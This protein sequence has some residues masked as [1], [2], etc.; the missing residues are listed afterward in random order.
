MRRPFLY[1]SQLH[2]KI[3]RLWTLF[4]MKIAWT[5]NTYISV[6][7][8]ICSSKLLTMWIEIREPSLFHVSVILFFYSGSP[9]GIGR[10]TEVSNTEQKIKK[11]FSDSTIWW[12]PTR[13]KAIPSCAFSKNRTRRMI[14]VWIFTSL[15]FF[16]SLEM[17]KTS[18]EGNVWFLL[19]CKQ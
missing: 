18:Q 8:F 16:R 5:R 6:L 3:F 11:I 12:K 19:I 9:A 4:G 14:S 13:Q 10:P 7:I 1:S 15:F 2:L 17:G